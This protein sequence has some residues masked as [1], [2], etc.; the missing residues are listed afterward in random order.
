MV[1]D[2]I[3]CD[4][5]IKKPEYLKSTDFQVSKDLCFKDRVLPGAT[6]VFDEHKVFPMT[7]K[8]KLL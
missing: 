4:P 3:V 2:F 1:P 6:L 5:D 7:Y 8:I